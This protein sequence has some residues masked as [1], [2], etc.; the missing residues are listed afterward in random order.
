MI[1]T[2]WDRY[3]PYFKR[4]EFACRCGCGAADMQ[5]DFMDSLLLLRKDLGKAMVVTSGFRCPLHNRNVSSTG[6][7]GPHTTG[8]ASDVLAAGAFAYKLVDLAFKYGFTGL[9]LQQKGPHT[10][11]Y[12]HLDTLQS[13]DHPRP[14]I[15]TY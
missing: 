15:W 3:A 10:G 14:G 7:S 6:E 1:V 11:R 4:E 8:C 5:I 9:G 13:P 12:V 2:N